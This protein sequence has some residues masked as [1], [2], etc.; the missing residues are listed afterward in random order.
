MAINFPEDVLEIFT[1]L[2]NDTKALISKSDPFKEKSLTKAELMAFAGRIWDVYKQIDN[3]IDQSFDD[4]RTGTYLEREA[5]DYGITRKVATV[6]NGNISVVGTATTI[7]PD[8]TEFQYDS[9]VYNVDG[10]TEITN[11]LVEVALV[12]SG[13]NVQVTFTDEHELGNGQDVTISGASQ[14]GLN[15]TYEMSV[16]DANTLTYSTDVVGAGSDSASAD[17]D[18]AVCAV[19]SDG[20]GEDYNLNSGEELEIGTSIVGVENQAVVT[21][22]GIGSGTDEETDAEL[23]ERLQQRKQYPAAFFNAAQVEA[24]LREISWVD[25]V[26]IERVTP[27]VG[28]AEIYLVKEENAIP[29]GTEITEAEDYFEEYLPINCDYTNIFI[30]APTAEEIPFTFSSISPDT[31]TM[32][33]AIEDNLE[34]FFLDRAEVGEGITEELYRG[35]IINTVDPESLSPLVSF[36]LTTPSGD[37]DATGGYLPILGTVTFS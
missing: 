5:S 4:T 19:V 26:F 33:T 16:L 9:L 1:Q 28:E 35:I 29:N 10:D 14:T 15:G 13:G 32:R 2:A 17:Y 6:A 31:A 34:A 11:K 27:S 23:R 25:R 30:L 36:T 7:V 3:L 20:F 8:G 12:Y 18:N 22:D 37:I 24:I 21:Y